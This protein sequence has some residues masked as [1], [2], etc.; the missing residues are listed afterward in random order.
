MDHDQQLKILQLR[1]LGKIYS[2]QAEGG[3]DSGEDED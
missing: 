3:N 1:F 2:E